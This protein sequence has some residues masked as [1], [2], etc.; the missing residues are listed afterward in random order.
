MKV[1]ICT[2][3]FESA[4]IAQECGA[5]RIELCTDLGVG[6]L[7]PSYDL[8][9]NVI[10]ELAIPV[11]VLVRP[12][13]GDFVYSDSEFEDMLSTI[14]FCRELG[15][16]GVVSGILTT[17]YEIDSKR[18]EKLMKA[19]KNMEFTF[20]RAFDS[21]RDPISTLSTLITLGVNRLLSS[22]QEFKALDGIPL[23]KQLLEYSEG[24]IEIMPG[25]GID[26]SNAA[27][28]KMAGFQ[29][30]HLSAIKKN[31]S[32]TNLFETGVSGISNSETIKKVIAA[33]R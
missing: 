15:C 4:R 30:I 9:Q 5:D 23:L 32:V 31:I 6:G 28:F 19:S 17:E 11:H 3:N 21:V 26:D 12:R 29:S 1:E 8:I 14:E 13:K 33:V 7:T 24:R 27:H 10:S 2:S 22:G 16:S 25:A 20:H 18:T